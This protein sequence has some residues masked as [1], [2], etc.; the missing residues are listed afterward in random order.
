MVDHPS[1]SQRQQSHHSHFPVQHRHHYHQDIHGPLSAGVV[2]GGHRA[3]AGFHSGPLHHPLHSSHTFS[4]PATSVTSASSTP[5]SSRPALSVS[6]I[7]ERYQDASKD[8]LVTVLNAKAKEDERKAEE[9]RYKTEQIKLQ[10]KQL[11]LELAVE[12]RRGSPPAARSYPAHSSEP[13]S[14]HYPS[15]SSYYGS[16]SY[17]PYSSSDTARSHAANGKHA[18]YDHVVHTPQDS[19]DHQSAHQGSQYS[20]QDQRSMQPTPQS[21]PPLKI[22]TSMRQYHPQP[23]SSQR[24]PPS[25]H[26]TLPPLPTTNPPK[27]PGRHY[28]LPPL[29]SSAQSS[30]VAVVDYQSHIPPPLT[31]KD[32]HVSPT[33]A[34]SPTL[35]PHMKRKSINH[36]A[37]MDA[38]RAKV[39]RNAGQN[40]QQQHHQKKVASELERE[41]GSRRKTFIE[42]TSP[43]TP[44]RLAEPSTTATAANPEPRQDE[45]PEIKTEGPVQSSLTHAASPVSPSSGNA[46]NGVAGS[47]SRSS[48]PPLSA[49]PRRQMSKPQHSQTTTAGAETQD[50][51]SASHYETDRRRADRMSENGAK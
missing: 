36:D 20:H 31:P 23:Q 2:E 30:P 47:H 3:F 39:F 10:A 14:G 9:E 25:P 15:T 51:T 8:F 38:V 1:S 4:T 17:Q 19:Q 34:L 27:P 26:S 44:K 50:D 48:S 6:D 45:R 42:R 5:A 41:Q 46:E 24:L 21:R 12:K 29:S 28:G 35:N 16:S 18:H 7:L 32:E 43:E 13:S 49:K 37:V 22:N 33:S 11:E 40:Q